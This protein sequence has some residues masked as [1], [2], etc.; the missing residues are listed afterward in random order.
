MLIFG[1][2]TS[3][4]EI[5]ASIFGL[6]SIRLISK[7]NIWN[8][9]I[10][11]VS[12]ILFMILF[13]K[14]KL[15]ANF[16]LQFYFLGIS[17]YGWILWKK[18]GDDLKITKL[19]N[20]KRIY[21]LLFIISSILISPYVNYLSP[22]PILDFSILSMSIVASYLMSRK[23]IDSWILWIIVDIIAIYLYYISGIYVISFEYIIV[24]LMAFNGLKKWNKYEHTI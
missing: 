22:H 6:V 13:F 14:I 1:Y 20:K 18:S 8:W 3:W 11:I 16:I 7:V 9:P 24:L 23:I 10:S 12:Q 15:F 17:I 5:F 2:P 19:T 4:L 21:C